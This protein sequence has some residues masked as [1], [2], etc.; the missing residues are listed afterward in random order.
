MRVFGIQLSLLLFFFS[1]NGRAQDP[2]EFAQVAYLKA[3]N[4]GMDDGTTASV[5]VSVA[6]SGDL[7][8]MGVPEEE[9][10][11]TGVNGDESDNRSRRSGAAYVFRRENE[12]WVQEAY[13]KASNTSILDDFGESVAISGDLIV[14]GASGEDSGATGVNGDQSDNSSGRSGAAYVFRRE[15]GGWSQ[16]AYLKASNTGEGDNFGS[17]V[18]IS[19]ETIVVGADSEGSDAIGVNG[20]QNNNS[21]EESGAAYVFR[22]ENGQWMQEAY[23]KASN[24]DLEDRFGVSVAISEETIVVGASRE[25]SGATRVNGDESD[26]SDLFTGAAYVFRRENEQWTQEAYLKASNSDEFDEFG[27]SVAISGETIV[28]GTP[29]EAS[30]A[31]RVNGGQND[32]SAFRA[33]AAYVFRRENG[34]WTQEA[35]LKAS[36]TDVNDEFGTSVSISGESIVVGAPFERSDATGVNGVQNDNSIFRPGAAYVFQR[37]NGQWTQEAYLKASNTDAGDE[38]GTS[39]AISAETIVVVAP[40][41]D[42]AGRGLNDSAA[43][44]GLEDS[45]ASYVFEM[46]EARGEPEIVVETEIDGV[47]EALTDQFNFARTELNGRREQEI[48]IRNEGEDDLVISSITV[49]S[50]SYL[51]EE[52]I[53]GQTLSPNT[54]ATFTLVFSPAVVDENPAI[55]RITSNDPDENFV[56]L[57]LLGQGSF[58]I[59]TLLDEAGNVLADDGVALDFGAVFSGSPNPLKFTLR[60]TGLARIDLRLIS[61]GSFFLSSDQDVL[62]VGEEAQVTL[63]FEPNFL[64]AHSETVELSF[65]GAESPLFSFTLTGL[66]LTPI[67]LAQEAYLKASNT[68]QLDNFGESVAISGDLIVVGAASEDSSATGVNG[69]QSDNSAGSFFSGSGS[70]A[71]YVFR[72]ENGQWMQ[73]AYLKA[74]NTD[75]GDH[76]GTSVA[77][78]GD[79]IVVGAPFEESSANSVNGRQGNNDAVF[80][81]AA[82]VFRQENGRWR[83]EAYLKAS[84]AG[85]GD[86]FGTIVDISGE[87]IVVGAPGEDSSSTGVNGN[88]GDDD[89]TNGSGAVYV[90]I[91]RNGRWIQ[92]AYLKSSNT[93]RSDQFGTSV[94][95]SEETIVVG[96]CDEESSAT[97]VDGDQSDDSLSDAGAA[98]VFQRDNGQWNQ[99]A[100]LKASNTDARDQFG[101]SVAISGEII[102]VGAFEEDSSATGVN[103]DQNNDSRFDSGAAYV[104]RREN[105]QWSQ[106]AYLKASN[107]DRR[108]QFGTSL[109]ISEETIVVGAIGEDS[110]AR[111]VNGDENDEYEYGRDSGAAYVFR[112]ENGQWI[113]RAYLKASNTESL[114]EF[115]SS[116]AIS[117]ENI[118]VGAHFEKSSAT[119]VNGEQNDNSARDSG[120]AYVF[121]EGSLPTGYVAAVQAAGLM[122]LNGLPEAT[123]FDD[124]VNNLLKYAF[125]LDLSGPDSRV[126]EPS[127]VSG[128][129][130]GETFGVAGDLFF[131]FEYVGLTNNEVI[132]EPQMSP[133]LEPGSFVPIPGVPSQE[134]IDTEWERFTFETPIDP[135]NTPRNF[136]RVDVRFR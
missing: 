61:R 90:F 25:G 117:G 56:T 120:A 66:S 92:E 128:L 116:V 100:Y 131:R 73:E 103:G 80:S 40:E 62:E 132:Y 89:A 136:F 14:V 130:F 43:S 88:Q 2:L 57:S 76:F 118:V 32:D 83:Q 26:N 41:E 87:T 97:G 119:G 110:L 127:G 64:G 113:Q 96:A 21:A 7:M 81:G 109:A 47:V 12:Q 27:R 69:D 39:V 54:A 104:F 58:P 52:T 16:E 53:A 108:Y 1:V 34:Q 44:N 29:F 77:I 115:G 79:V 63:T 99:E 10:S 4:A 126:L 98:Y 6:I 107:T 35:Y 70:G 8:V 111:G 24:T 33:G 37:E 133:T 94:S 11:A 22:R 59:I 17:I 106:E 67:G 121:L 71:V 50:A 114:D 129:P 28:V 123:P 36:N 74:S 20:D 23:L 3:S 135:E 46:V 134:S 105:G 60:N 84:N 18:A 31:T 30:D 15:N 101:A 95:I 124:G 78:S 72:R 102:V 49:D 125:N 82:Y 86:R 122:G 112:R 51:I 68:E 19:G 5:S 45:A 38:F 42:G 48:T 75:D 13:L 91:R 65:E 55:L 9:S 85:G 93:D